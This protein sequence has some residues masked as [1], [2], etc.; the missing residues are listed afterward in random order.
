MKLY[1]IGEL[2]WLDYFFSWSEYIVEFVTVW[3]YEWCC[4]IGVLAVWCYQSDNCIQLKLL[5]SFY[6]WLQ[7]LRF[8][9]CIRTLRSHSLTRK[10]ILIIVY[11]NLIHYLELSR[12]ANFCF[13]CRIKDMYNHVSERS[14]QKAALIADDV[15]EIIMKVIYVCN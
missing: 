6:S 8:Q 10:S 3:D 7:G 2:V 9:I 4:E 13:Y 5:W 15:Y 11:S 14:G 1:D 12:N